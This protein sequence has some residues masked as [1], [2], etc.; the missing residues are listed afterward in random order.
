MP[1]DRERGFSH[2]RVISFLE[3]IAFIRGLPK[4]L[5]FDNGAELTSHAIL[6]W[7]AERGIELHFI[8]PGKPIQ[9]AFVESFNGKLRDECLNEHAFSS[10]DEA[11]RLIS[12]WHY[13]Y[14][15]CA[16][17]Q[18]WTTERLSS[19]PLRRSSQCLRFAHYDGDTR[20]DHVK[21]ATS[22]LPYVATSHSVVYA[23]TLMAG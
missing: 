3:R 1:G 13:E 22:P 21:S 10:I 19:S 6:R 17:T 15:D 11:R 20:G 7:G 2:R 4:T 14:N 23:L 18:L 8:D 16:H 5:R 12:A 9:S